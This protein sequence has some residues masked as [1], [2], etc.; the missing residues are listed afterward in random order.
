MYM[1]QECRELVWRSM[2]TAELN[3]RYF[4]ALGARYRTWDRSAKVLLAITGST[5]VAGWSFWS[6]TEFSWMWK[7]A[8][9]VG[10]VVGLVLPIFDPAKTIETAERLH[11]AWFAILRDY[12]VLW[13]TV[14]EANETEGRHA[15]DRI[16]SEEKRLAEI[17]VTLRKH[18]GLA[19]RCEKQVRQSRG[20]E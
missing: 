16:V 4:G 7:L 9:V 10:A 14:D 19:R 18:H 20:L 2:L 12:E 15:I 1:T 8:S 11:G 13:S 17:E 5:T 6:M 3:F